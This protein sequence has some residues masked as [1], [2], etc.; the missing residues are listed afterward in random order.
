MWTWLRP[1]CRRSSLVVAALGLMLAAPSASGAASES[2]LQ[3]GLATTSLTSHE[4]H[5]LSNI[6][7]ERVDP[8]CWKVK[9]VCWHSPTSAKKSAILFGD[10]HVAMWLP[11]V[12]AQLRKY[13]VQVWWHPSCPVASVTPWSP[14]DQAFNQSCV[15]WRNDTISALV[16]AR[17]Q[18]IVMAERTSG[19][20]VQPGQLIEQRVLTAALGQSFTQLAKS[21]ARLALVGDTP[22]FINDPVACLALHRTSARSC[23]IDRSSLPV[24]QQSLTNAEAAA[25]LAHRVTFIDPRPWVCSKTLC[26]ALLGKNVGYS[27]QDHFTASAVSELSSRFGA[28]IAPALR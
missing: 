22:S 21:G 16:K 15:K 24:A 12:A 17:P 18:L 6:N 14:N 25:A 19:L 4:L 8:W 2:P 27:D 10:S 11:A 5:Q 7:V 1:W 26:P 28:E 20:F 23:A 3:Q 9:G 13:Q